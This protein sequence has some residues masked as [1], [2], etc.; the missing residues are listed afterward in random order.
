MKL[1][2]SVV[3][4]LSV[5]ENSPTFYRDDE[6]RGF[7]VKVFTSGVKTFFLEKKINGRSRRM[8]IGRYGE[9]TVEQARR[10]ATKLAGQIVTGGD[11]V[12]E[13]AQKKIASKS[14]R[15]VFE[16][17][18]G[19]RELKPQ[20]L[21]DIRRCMNEVYPDWLDKPFTKITP[22][23][24]VKRHR[25]YGDKRSPARAN[26]AMRYLRAIFNFALVEY[27]NSEG[28]SLLNQNP[29]GKLSQTK[30]WHRIERR[31]SLIK[32]HELGLWFRTVQTIE[33]PK[34]RDYLTLL[35]MTGL[36]RQEA[37]TL[38]WSDVDMVGRTLT[39]RDP[40][41]RQPHTLPLSD[42]LYNM[43]LEANKR[44]SNEYVFPGTG[45]GGHLVEPRK[46]IAKAVEACGIVFTPHDLRR[47]FATV[48]ESL[49]IPAYAV[50]ALLNHKTGA[51]VTGGYL[52]ISPERL[53]EPMQRISQYIL[54]KA[55][56]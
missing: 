17:Y 8:S 54:S 30:S 25:E 45:A 1:T 55:Q 31:R 38:K 21:F 4:K 13:K 47:T 36:R 22:D 53:R 32:V 23:M 52:V 26:L 5:P 41:N 46:Q 6:I 2:K 12:T 37:A 29:V 44:K 10:E 50:K 56:F 43:L 7:G 40:K 28:K 42:Y 3:D 51:D 19:R 18:M 9:L 14:L 49:D 16:T 39:V 20:T 27:T 35:V 48:A 15:E 24:I 11:P 34:L 33:N